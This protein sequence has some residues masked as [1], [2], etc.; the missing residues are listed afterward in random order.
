MRWWLTTD[1]PK[2]FSVGN[3]AVKGMDFS[4][5][6]PLVWMVQWH[7]GENKGEIEYQTEDG[8]NENGLR[9]EFFDVTP[10]APFFDQFLEL[11][12][13]LTLPQAKKVKIDLV[14]VIFDSKRQLPY[15]YPVTAGDYW[16]DASDETMGASTNAALQNTIAKLN[17]VIARVNGLAASVNATVV[18][19][20]NSAVVN[21]VNTAVVGGVNSTVVGGVNTVV[22]AHLNTV[23]SVVQLNAERLNTLVGNINSQIV[24]P[25]NTALGEH[26]SYTVAPANAMRE[27]INNIVLGSY[28]NA[29]GA[30]NNINNRLYR[31][32]PPEQPLSGLGANIAHIPGA[33]SNISTF[34]SGL[35]DSFSGVGATGGING[36]GG[37]GGINA[38]DWPTIANVPT[39]NQQWIPIGATAPVNVTPAEQ[40]AIMSGIAART[41][42]LNLKRNTKIG[43]INT[44]TT[45]QAVID[46]DVTTGW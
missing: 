26:N 4:A 14:N 32:Q 30:P 44:L 13:G 9:E 11:L 41:N 5:L 15:H 28:D 33:F 34:C 1:D 12:S 10:F 22:V 43:E 2:I 40:A 19:G 38:I 46:Y 25:T 36:I 8:Q 3:A 27:H 39:S 35:G 37:I 23:A 24:S 21:G 42:D 7:P 31:W 6:D 29:T 45:V 16:W 17:E 18:G 20:V